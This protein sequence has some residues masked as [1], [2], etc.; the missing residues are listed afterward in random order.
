MLISTN[1]FYFS[2]ILLIDVLGTGC[3]NNTFSL[4]AIRLSSQDL[5]R[6]SSWSVLNVRLAMDYDIFSMVELMGI[7]F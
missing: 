6:L 1:L 3:C 7:I 2:T 5:S 4:M